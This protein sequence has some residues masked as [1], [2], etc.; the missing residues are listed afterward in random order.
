MGER[1]EH[2]STATVSPPAL[3]GGA[4]DGSVAPGTVLAG[5]FEVVR[6]LGAGGSGAVYSARDLALGQEVAVKVLHPHL[7]DA[8]SRE[9]LRREVRAAR[10]GHPGLVA[11][12]DLHEAEGRFFLSLELVDGRS[13]REVLAERGPMP[14]DD[15]VAIGRQLAET[16][17]WLHGRGLVHR[18]VKPGNVLLEGGGRARLCDLG[19]VRPLEQGATVTAT[20]TVVGTPAYMAPE[21]AT[22]APLTGAADVYGLGLTLYCA[23]TGEVPLVE[24]TAV[25]TLVRR[26]RERAPRVRRSRP[27]CP[28]WLG[29]LLGAMLEPRPGD[30][31][32]AARVVEVLDRR[33][34][35]PRVRWR[36]VVAAAGVVLGLA[37]VALALL[38]VVPRVTARL[39]VAGNRVHGVDARGRETWHLDLETPVL[40]DQRVDL[41]GDG[42]E[43]A[44]LSCADPLVAA[45]DLDERPRA[46]VVVV[47]TNGEVVTRALLADHIGVWPSEFPLRLVPNVQAVELDGRWPRELVVVCRHRSFYPTALLV[48]WT[49]VG[50]WE[51]VVLHS[52]AV[53]SLAIRRPPEG[54]RLLLQAVNNPLGMAAVLAEVELQP[55][56]ARKPLSRGV[57]L[58]SPDLLQGGEPQKDLGVTWRRYTLLPP[59]ASGPAS[60]DGDEVVLGEGEARF[61]LDRYGN[62]EGSPLWGRDLT[63]ERVRVL[64]EL[65]AL[66]IDAWTAGQA[67]RADVAA[68]VDDVA[69]R[70]AE[71]L[72]EQPYRR[73]H[74]VQGA[75][76][77][78]CA[79]DLAGARVLVERV[80]AEG[81]GDD[82][83]TLRLANLEAVDTLLDRA[84]SRLMQP[85]GQPRTPRAGYDIPH[86]ALRVAIARRDRE[87]HA[88]VASLFSARYR[89]IMPDSFSDTLKARAR[90]WW[91]EVEPTDTRVQSFDL[92]PGGEAVACLARWR[93]GVTGADDPERMKAAA[94]RDPEAGHEYHAAAGAALL[95]LGRP[96]EALEVL[97]AAIVRLQPDARV[98]F[99]HLQTLE[100]ARAL[101]V[102]A[103]QAAGSAEAARRE[104]E[105]LAGELTPGLLP[106]RLV[107]EALGG[108]EE[109]RRGQ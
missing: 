76:A 103:L 57:T 22:G 58:V 36:R 102:V 59:A 15:V 81:G 63:R 50:R 17:S 72:R 33:A 37:A 84:W 40:E 109:R 87:G 44:V 43:E 5:R 99:A 93:L 24:S 85:M 6:R 56:E 94:E 108:A 38:A 95:G 55:L 48:H 54:A 75:R 68:Q 98:D 51:Q 12:Y 92:A 100:L 80:E 62:P 66:S 74:A 53:Y 25:A 4:P 7:A 107:R 10:P 83:L 23:L 106:E 71:I 96:V 31:P 104:G 2:D 52:G 42:V 86:L 11:A 46:E 64:S 1:G 65:S 90:L 60:Y 39:E 97:N 45:G 91:D 13:L 32:T 26:Q 27:D 18:D 29:R 88:T 78:A 28:A 73:V 34:M 41:D 49:A 30:R 14:S 35:A 105:A 8:A 21:Q 19:L 70:Y 20:E 47:R 77:L 101:R 61:R 89:E 67:A 3:N 69:R 82:D 16:L 79:G 9:R